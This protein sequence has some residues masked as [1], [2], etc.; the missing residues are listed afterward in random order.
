MPSREEIEN[1]SLKY[2]NCMSK[3]CRQN[4]KDLKSEYRD[5]R[6]RHGIRGTTVPRDVK[7]KIYDEQS[8]SKV[9]KAYTACAVQQCTEDLKTMLDSYKAHCKEAY[10]NTGSSYYKKVIESIGAID[11]NKLSQASL[12][13]LFMAIYID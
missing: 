10:R 11:T 9:G 5:I 4:A 7:E 12:E 3:R 6:N 13:K 2:F 1:P 8:R